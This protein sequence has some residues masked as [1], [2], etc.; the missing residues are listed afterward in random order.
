LLLSC[1]GFEEIYANARKEL[2]VSGERQAADMLAAEAT[3]LRGLMSGP[4]A[5]VEAV[6]VEL[7]R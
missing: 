7:R 5:S 6:E 2:A 1:T 3:K 4:N